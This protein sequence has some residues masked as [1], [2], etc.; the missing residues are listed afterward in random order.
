MTQHILSLTVWVQTAKYFLQNYWYNLGLWLKRWNLF[1]FFARELWTQLTVSGW[2]STYCLAFFCC[3]GHSLQSVDEKVQIDFVFVR[4]LWMGTANSLWLR[5]WNVFCFLLK[6]YWHYLLV[7]SLSE[8][9]QTIFFLPENYWHNLLVQSFT[10]E[11]QTVLPFLGELLTQSFTEEEQTILLFPGELII[12]Q[13]V[14]WWKDINSFAFLG[15]II[16]TT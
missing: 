6:N 9:K 7:Q 5:R 2:K 11:E 10:E 1:C 3:Y 15:R 13:R 8:E 14:S 4:E 12:Q 16:N